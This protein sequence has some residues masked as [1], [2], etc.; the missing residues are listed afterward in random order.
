VLAGWAVSLGAGP[1]EE[2]D[3]RFDPTA[4]PMLERLAPDAPAERPEED[5]PWAR[6]DRDDDEVD[7]AERAGGL[8]MVRH[9]YGGVRSEQRTALIDG[10][11]HVAGDEWAGAPLVQVLRYGVSLET[12]DET[13]RYVPVVDHGVEKTRRLPEEPPRVKGQ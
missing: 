2:G 5:A 12:D 10:R 4:P 3:V 7:P 9:R 1:P 8:Q 11:K 13:Y 6:A